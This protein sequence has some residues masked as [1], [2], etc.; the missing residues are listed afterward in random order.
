MR[1]KM[2]TDREVR[3]V[4]RHHYLTR[5]NLGP[6]KRVAR[7]RFRRVAELELKKVLVAGDYDL[8]GPHLGHRLTVWD[9]V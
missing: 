8:A 2:V 1:E 9:V 7:R 5:L 4:V 6:I 3:E